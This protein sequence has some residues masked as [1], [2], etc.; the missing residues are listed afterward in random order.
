MKS[1]LQE[2]NPHFFI[3]KEEYLPLYER[4]VC[5]L[6]CST[7]SIQL[8][9]GVMSYESFIAGN[10]HPGELHSRSGDPSGPQAYPLVR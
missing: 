9:R 10:E 3:T 8:S 4:G 7:P 1:L 6:H 5:V 2:S